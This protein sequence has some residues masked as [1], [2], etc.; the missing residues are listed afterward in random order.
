MMKVESGGKQISEF[1]GLRAKLYSY[2]TDKYEKKKCKGITKNVIIKNI[3]FED[4]KRTILTREIPHRRMNYV[5]SP[6]DELFI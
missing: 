2:K 4:Y 5:S 3:G 6:N 1:V